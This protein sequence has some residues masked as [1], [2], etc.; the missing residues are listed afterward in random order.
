MFQMVCDRC[1]GVIT[2]KQS[3]IV[4]YARQ[5][6]TAEIMFQRKTNIVLAHL[7]EDCTERLVD[8]ITEGAWKDE[9]KD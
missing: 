9:P 5:D 1:N 4:R 6:N 7:C 3:D 8:W 2:S